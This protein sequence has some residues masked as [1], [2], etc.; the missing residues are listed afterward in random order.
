MLLIENSV[1]LDR[2]LSFTSPWHGRLI[3]CGVDTYKLF[4]L[5]QA[6][7]LIATHSD[8]FAAVLKEQPPVVTMATLQELSLVTAVICHSGVGEEHCYSSLH[9]RLCGKNNSSITHRHTH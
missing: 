8:V 6:T 7:A 1:E 4:L 5:P 3:V 2:L 9:G